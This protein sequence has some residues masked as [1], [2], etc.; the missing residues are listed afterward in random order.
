MGSIAIRAPLAAPSTVLDDLDLAVRT[1]EKAAPRTRR[2][3]AALVS[4]VGPVM[5]HQL[6]PSVSLALFK[7][8]ASQG[9]LYLQQRVEGSVCRPIGATRGGTPVC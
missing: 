3:R 8:V 1:Y 4:N 5:R 2:A 6:T 7:E 9:P